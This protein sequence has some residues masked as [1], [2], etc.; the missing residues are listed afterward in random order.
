[1]ELGASGEITDRWQ[2]AGG[3]V[4][5]Q[6]LLTSRTGANP[7]GRTVPLVPPRAASL[8]NRVQVTTALALGLGGAAPGDARTPRSTTR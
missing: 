5:Q 4:T 1:V 7:D 8:W 3:F 2:V 6:A